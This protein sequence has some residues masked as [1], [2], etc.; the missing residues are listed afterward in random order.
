MRSMCARTEAAYLTARWVLLGPDRK[1][2]ADRRNT[3]VTA[4]EQPGSD[5]AVAAAMTGAVGQLAETIA[6]AVRGR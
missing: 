4:V 2:L 3:F 6:A 5:A 1:T